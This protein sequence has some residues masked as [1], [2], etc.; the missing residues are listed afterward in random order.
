M[1]KIAH[2]CNIRFNIFISQFRHTYML[3]KSILWI[4]IHCF[5]LRMY[6]YLFALQLNFVKYNIFYIIC[7]KIFNA[8]CICLDW[9]GTYHTSDSI[10]FS[11]NVFCRIYIYLMFRFKLLNHAVFH[12]IKREIGNKANKTQSQYSLA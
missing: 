3:W 1:L 11:Y 9:I 8:Y 2:E 12:F 10:S 7:I 6:S 5:M 4:L